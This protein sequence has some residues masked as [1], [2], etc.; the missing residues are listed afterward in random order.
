MR[1]RSIAMLIGFLMLALTA[2]PVAAITW[3]QPDGDQHPQVVALFF[4]QA[5]G[6]QSCSGT[7]LS[8]YV[9]LTAAHCTQS[10]GQPNLATWVK[11]DP[12]I[13]FEEIGNYPDPFSYLNNEWTPG[14]AVSHPNFDDFAGLPNTHDVGVVLLERPIYVA[15]YGQL[16]ELGQFNSL[17]TQR[18][19]QNPFFRVVGYG[20]Q[21]IVPIPFGQN[22]FT[23]YQGEVRLTNT[24]S[25]YTGGYNFQFSNNPGKGN[26]AGGTCF[27]DSGGPAFYQDTSI[28]AAITSYGITP[29]CT[30]SSY[31]YR[32]DIAE[33]LDFVSP[34]LNWQP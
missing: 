10:G 21:A 25:S 20:V 34:Y 16:P 1:K 31:S 23:R 13:T 17:D 30:G 27:G 28:V 24:R 15:Q 9:V 14:T 22:D 12:A 33:T 3:G 19:R 11:N 2:L 18:G 4:L 29:H 6:F 26:G 5:N 32:T 7:L 8:P